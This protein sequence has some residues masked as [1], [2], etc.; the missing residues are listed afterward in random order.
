VVSLAVAALVVLITG[1]TRCIA[2]TTKGMYAVL[3]AGVVTSALVFLLL[4]WLSGRVSAVTNSA[5]FAVQV[6]TTCLFSSVFLNTPITVDD[7]I[8]APLV[9][10]GLLLVCYVQYQE[11]PATAST[12]QSKDVEQQSVLSER[13]LDAE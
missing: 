11:D 2:V 1:S 5:F 7:L 3:Y 10:G 13:L 8:G 6:L 9:I 12:L 4:S